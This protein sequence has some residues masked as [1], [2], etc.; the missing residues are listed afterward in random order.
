MGEGA[1]RNSG[2]SEEGNWRVNAI[3]RLSLVFNHRP[4]FVFLLFYIE[5]YRQSEIVPCHLFTDVSYN[6][7]LR[8]FFFIIKTRLFLLFFW[9]MVLHCTVAE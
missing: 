4:N 3:P 9:N 1:S 6:A 7:R 5:I 8:F 2:D